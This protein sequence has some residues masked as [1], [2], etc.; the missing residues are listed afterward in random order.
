M[1][2]NKITNSEGP[3]KVEKGVKMERK[4]SASARFP[5]DKMEIGD[6]F[7]IPKGDQDPLTVGPTIYAAS[8]SYNKTH[9]TKIKVAIRKDTDGVRVFR[10][11]DRK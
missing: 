1:N 4:R 8:N 10:I 3:Y 5:F 6:S 7:F 11:E 2:R 9:G